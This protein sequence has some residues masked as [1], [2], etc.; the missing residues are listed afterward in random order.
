M[1]PV[2]YYSEPIVLV[3]VV[4]E[5]V[6]VQVAP[7]VIAVKIRDVAVVVPVLPDRTSVQNTIHATTP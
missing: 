7:A 1:K 6:E 2:S 5:P 3:P 4:L